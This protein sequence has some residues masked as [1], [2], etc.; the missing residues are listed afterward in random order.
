MPRATKVVGIERFASNLKP[1]IYEEFM[2]SMSKTPVFLARKYRIPIIT[3]NE[4]IR[5]EG[6][7]LLRADKQSDS[8]N[9]I[10]EEV[11][12]VTRDE[13]PTTIYKG[14]RKLVMQLDE[15]LEQKIGA[16][17]LDVQKKYLELY[18]K[19]LDLD[20]RLVERLGL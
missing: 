12:L 8:I 6:W 7:A 2:S 13:I 9:K 1:T 20:N 15:I 4:W 10:M 14:V 17:N 19:A 5:E 18:N 11:G 3:L 16:E